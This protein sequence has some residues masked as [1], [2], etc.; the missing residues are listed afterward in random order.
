MG[1]GASNAKY[2]SYMLKWQFNDE[3]GVYRLK[4]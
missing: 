1:E 2:F 4:S 3:G